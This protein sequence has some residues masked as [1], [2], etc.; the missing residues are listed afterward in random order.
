MLNG[1]RELRDLNGQWKFRN[2]QHKHEPKCAILAALSEGKISESRYQSF[3]RIVD[4]LQDVEMR[5]IKSMEA[6]TRTLP[7]QGPA[8]YHI[9]YRRLPF[10]FAIY[11][12]ANHFD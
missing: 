7:L 3:L 8:D 1:F 6:F 11:Q 12:V 10:A 9:G 4:S 5:K 2:R